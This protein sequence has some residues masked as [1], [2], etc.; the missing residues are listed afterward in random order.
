MSAVEEDRSLVRDSWDIGLSNGRLV[1]L[2]NLRDD[3]I[4]IEVIA[5]SLSLQCRYMGHVKHHYSVAQHC[6]Y[7]CDCIIKENRVD[8]REALAGLLHDA[9]EA[10]LHDL[11]RAIKVGLLDEG[12]Q[13][14]KLEAKIQKQIF[15]KYG[16]HNHQQYHKQIKKWDNRVLRSEIDELIP[17]ACPEFRQMIADIEPAGVVIEKLAPWQVEPMFLERFHRLCKLS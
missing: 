2:C 8:C 11:V 10:Y 17:Q 15:L 4:D 5:H 16:L 6:I 3:E 14:N 12:S 9:S 7:V 1:D 13:W